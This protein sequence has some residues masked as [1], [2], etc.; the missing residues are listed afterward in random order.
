LVDLTE[1]SATGRGITDL[2]G[3]QYCANL[4]KLELG[5]EYVSGTGSYAKNYIVDI[6]P[7]VDLANLTELDL[8]ANEIIDI[9]PLW[10]LPNLTKLDLRA[11]KIVDI[12]LLSQLTNLEHLYLSENQ[13]VD[14]SP[15]AGLPNLTDLALSE[16]QIIDISSLSS[17]TSLTDLALSDNEIVDI[18]PLVQNAGLGSGTKIDVSGNLLDT[19]TG[20]LDM[21]RISYM[22][23]RGAE[24]EFYP[25]R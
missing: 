9:S 17:L 22:I 20:S 5:S 24:V 3:I 21:E 25:Q 10:R 16:N 18:V 4:T 6:S 7:L 8:R 15:L 2:E 14:I 23:R 11:N 19:S 1:L 12:S 13:I